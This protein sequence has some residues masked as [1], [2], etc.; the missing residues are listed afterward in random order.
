VVLATAATGTASAVGY[1]VAALLA[2]QVATG[3]AKAAGYAALGIPAA[4][5]VGAVPDALRVEILTE[6]G[7]QLTADLAT[8]RNLSFS[9]EHNGSGTIS[10]ETDLD[11]LTNGIDSA[12]LAPSNLV[13]VHYGDLSAWPNGVAE[14]FITSAPPVKDDSGRWTVQVSGPG[15]WDALDFAEL[16]PPAGAVGDTREFSYTAGMTGA[17]FVA[18]EWHK[19]AATLVT[20]SF[21]WKHRY[22]RGWPEK[23]ARWIWSSSPEKNSANGI[24]QF[25]GNFTLTATKNVRFYA[26]GDDNLKLYLNGARIKTKGRGG[27]KKTASVT[28]RLAAGTY[29][30]AAAVANM[31][32]GDNKSGFICAVAQLKADG[33]REKWLLRSGSDTFQVKVGSTFLGTVPLPPDGWYPAAVLYQ[34][35]AEAKAR[36]V[37]F[38]AGITVTFSTTA[39]SSGTAW[40]AKGQ[41]EYDIG[42]SGAELGE[43]IRSGG[44]DVAM[45]PGLKLSA[46]TH[47]GFDLRDRVVISAPMGTGWGSR[48]WPRVRTVGL[49]HHETGWTETSGDASALATF[50][51]RELTISGG[52][53]DGDI[54][55]NILAAAALT[56]AGAPEETIEVTITSAD[57]R[58]GAPQPFRDFN[59]ADIISVE[60]VGGFTPI[61]VMTIS[62]AEQDTKEVRWT[63]AGY[64]V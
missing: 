7:T 41:S 35:I 33:T 11:A 34:H 42:I 1:D 60:T 9:V 6:T 29:T 52:G 38:H 21:R 12:L 24:R 28:R 22:P 17:A 30:V 54:Q 13:R 43:K 20:S 25:F 4:P 14:G 19:P 48:A 58:T 49:T 8:R 53:T 39:D 45:L 57:L 26:A 37:D 63:I 32:G 2:A 56:S 59:V 18:E 46:W 47:R 10:F 15:S 50:G 3:V 23:K 51:R 36:G 55:A 61:K 62:G 31:D 27:W 16:W 44:V 5:P 40:T 64:P